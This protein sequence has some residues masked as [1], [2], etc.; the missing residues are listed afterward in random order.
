MWALVNG[1]QNV[2]HPF[3]PLLVADDGQPF[4][5]FPMLQIE[6]QVFPQGSGRPAVEVLHDEQDAEP[7][8]LLNL[9]IDGGN[10]F[11]VELLMSVFP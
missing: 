5:V 2:G 8:V 6:L 3:L 1:L 11:L 10:E 9:R 7:S 4:D